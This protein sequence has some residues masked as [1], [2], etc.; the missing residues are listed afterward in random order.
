M[1]R[2]AGRSHDLG[3]TQDAFQRRLAGSP[4]KVEHSLLGAKLWLA[5]EPRSPAAEALALVIAGHHMGLPNHGSVEAG[6]RPSKSL[7]ERL[8]K[9]VDLH[10][11]VG[12]LPE[13]FLDLPLPELLAWLTPTLGRR[14][15]ATAKEALARKRELWIRFLFSA[16]VDADFLDTERFFR[17]DR[18]EQVP[19]FPAV[20]ELRRRLD[21]HVDGLAASARAKENAEG[22]PG[23]VNRVRAEVL[24]ACRDSADRDPGLFSLTV[25]T[26]GGKTLASMSFALRHAERHGLRRVIV[27][28]PYTSILEQN[29]GVFAEALGRGN[30]VEH[31]SSFEDEKLAKEDDEVR[32]R[33]ELAAENWDAPVVVTT[34]VQ[35]FESLF[36]NRTSRCR[37]LHNIARSVII[38]DE[39]QTVPPHLLAPILDVL[40]Q[41]VSGFGCSVV[42]STAT[43]PAWRE[44][45]G[46]PGGVEHVREIAPEPTRLARTLARYR[47]EWRI[48]KEATWPDLANELATFEQV[49]CVVHRRADA[50]EL[51]ERLMERTGDGG[52]IHLSATMCGAHRD[53]VLTEIRRRLKHGEPCRVISTQLVEAGVDVDFPIVFRALAGLDSLIQAAGRCNREGTGPMGRFVVFR[54]PTRPPKGAPRRGL[55]ILE[56]MLVHGDRPVDPHDPA[57]VER[58]FRS[59]YAV[60]TADPEG[61]QPA[62]AARKFATTAKT[63]RMIEDDWSRPVAVPW[64]HGR[65]LVEALESPGAKRKEILRKL[66]RFTVNAPK[67]QVDAWLQQG[68]ARTVD[69]VVVTLSDPVGDLYTNLFGLI[70]SSEPD[71]PPPR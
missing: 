56:A 48:D 67:Q 20:A 41:L 58:Y 65:A 10:A 2:L 66:Q 8:Q 42:V 7:R 63:F 53:E 13:G 24:A 37:K 39:A 57:D 52:V 59:F 62:R 40:R 68:V 28:I 23:A 12:R 38:L 29:A 26:G 34:N 36:S 4:E 14:P 47:T 64:G 33:H 55:E 1:A 44:R 6:D 50:R 15:T 32:K 46:F 17:G 27:A 60:N 16:L 22:T 30:V 61:I 9:P 21:A 31:H 70:G 45:L 51:A 3:K 5:R 71:I 35:L 19:T 69:E 49:L 43:Q 11:A 25:P 54:A 18:R